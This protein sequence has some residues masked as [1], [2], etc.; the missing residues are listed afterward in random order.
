MVNPV[1]TSFEDVTLTL[2][3]RRIFDGFD[4]ELR[5]RRVGL[6]GRNGSGKSMLARLA[7]GLVAPD[8]GKVRIEGADI[9]RD[10]AEAIRL[11]GI[12]FQNPDHQIIFPTVEEELA[13]GLTQ[14]GLGRRAARAGATET[15]AAFGKADWAERPIA[16]LSQGQRHL[17]CLMAVL[18]MAP[19][20]VIL[21]EPFAGLDAPTIAQLTRRLGAVEQNLL[22][23]SHDLAALADYD[24]VIWIEAGRILRDGDPGAVLAE[25]AERMAR[26][27]ADECSL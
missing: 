4:L 22:H 3:G 10:R 12:L 1:H 2:D 6:V 25:Y 16:T 20:L 5:E 15:L 13:F 26:A 17:V 19:R 24:R 14:Q 21:D 7:A 11:V 9:F 8:H 23:A 27:G 18:A